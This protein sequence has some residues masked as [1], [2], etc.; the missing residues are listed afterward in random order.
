MIICSTSTHPDSFGIVPEV[1]EEAPYLLIFETDDG[2]LKKVCSRA[3]GA[4]FSKETVD[5]YAEAIVM[6]EHIGKEAFSPIADASITRYNGAGRRVFEAV[7]LAVYNRLPIIK[8][9]LGGPGCEGGGGDCH[10]HDFDK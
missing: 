4:D 7:Q 3:K 8:E 5:C 9:Y 6:G 2:S 10:E 1:F